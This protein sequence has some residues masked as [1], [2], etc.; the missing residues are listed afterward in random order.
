LPLITR[1]TPRQLEVL[2][3]VAAGRTRA[4]IARALGL[5]YQTVQTHCDDAR[6]RLKAQN[7]PQA[8]AEAIVRGWLVANR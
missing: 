1:P 7:L 2:A 6:R 8:V 4:E 3:L 5:S